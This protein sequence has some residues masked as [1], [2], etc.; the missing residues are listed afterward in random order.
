MKKKFRIFRKVARSFDEELPILSSR[1]AYVAQTINFYQSQRRA[2]VL[3]SAT[4]RH[5]YRYSSGSISQLLLARHAVVPFI[6]R[7]D[8]LS[9]LSR[10]RDSD[11][12]ASVQVILGAGG[13]G[14]TRLASE[15]GR[16]SVDLGWIISNAKIGFGSA[17]PLKSKERSTGEKGAIGRLILIDYSDRLD[18]DS[19]VEL[20]AELTVEM[21]GLPLRLLLTARSGDWWSS[22]QYSLSDYGIPV[23]V[24]QLVEVASSRGARIELF[25][26]A[27][28]S[29][30]DHLGIDPRIAPGDP[31]VIECG[32]SSV[33]AVE[34]QALVQVQAQIE[35]RKA[36]LK[37][38]DVS[39]H[40]LEREIINWRRRHSENKC[41]I[42]VKT[43]ARACFLATLVPCVEYEYTKNLIDSLGVATAG[44]SADQIIFDH[45]SYYPSPAGSTDVVLSPILPNRLGEDFIAWQLEGGDGGVEAVDPWMS[46]AIK[47]IIDASIKA[48]KL[49]E[50]A[51]TITI[52]VETSC[53][54]RSVALFHLAPLLESSPGLALYSGPAVLAKL[55]AMPE[56]G[57]KTIRSL[58]EDVKEKPGVQFSEAAALLA[59]RIALSLEQEAGHAKEFI[60][61]S[62]DA[63]SFFSAAGRDRDAVLML[64]KAMR[65]SKQLSNIDPE[66]SLKSYASILGSL[67]SALSETGR[68]KMALSLTWTSVEL[69]R[70]I[71]QGDENCRNV[72]ATHQINLGNRLTD[73][74]RYNDALAVVTDAV[75]SLSLQATRRPTIHIMEQLAHAQVSL[76]NRLAKLGQIDEARYA[77]ERSVTT[78]GWLVRR[79]PAEYNL[80][81]AISLINFGCRLSETGQ[82]QEALRVTVKAEEILRQIVEQNYWAGIRWHVR[83]LMNLALRNSE[84]G[85]FDKFVTTATEA[86]SI[87]RKLYW[88]EPEAYRSELT[89]LLVVHA[90]A[91]RK[92]GDYVAALE[93]AFEAQKYFDQSSN[94]VAQFEEEFEGGLLALIGGLLLKQSNLASA[95]WYLRRAVESFLGLNMEV[96]ITK[97]AMLAS[98]ASDYS[99]ALS[100]MNDQEGSY[101]FTNLALYLYSALAERDYAYYA[102]DVAVCLGNL[103][104]RC[105]A[106]GRPM[107]AIEASYSA[108]DL[109]ARLMQ[110]DHT[111]HF[112]KFIV[113][114][115]NLEGLIRTV[116]MPRAIWASAMAVDRLR[117]LEGFPGEVEWCE[118]QIRL[119][120]L[121]SA[122]MIDDAEVE[123]RVQAKSVARE[124]LSIYESNIETLSD[125]L[126][127]QDVVQV[128]RTIS[129]EA[130][131]GD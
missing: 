91:L 57:I 101:N 43:M 30:A 31:S 5:E 55:A 70:H 18:L 98:A 1:D 54:Q 85:N 61:L 35:N 7:V 72:L 20:I 17:N 68:H 34:M 26:L 107:G 119:L 28:E 51:M 114:G 99:L 89:R 111:K 121:Y 50:L 56:L 4:P 53:R 39:I 73:A 46:V 77:T 45:R 113:A 83:A 37:S 15:F 74:R 63:A 128:A 14:K 123:A 27:Y 94:D 48:S 112:N 40:L 41:A 131:P 129:E 106:T 52:L 22:L 118:V 104:W 125:N 78:Y 86:V 42:G 21:N 110:D 38:T 36:P 13:Q 87:G 66:V 100:M 6:G 84:A 71:A 115:R 105:M 67:G 102:E 58:Y 117:E 95:V 127:I 10:W 82:R 93:V 59:R 19:I 11:R 122:I 130:T 3:H 88:R 108:F 65:K 8:E 47:K 126:D 81:Y 62:V 2:I 116:C 44:E 23:C 90:G 103:S 124:A 12:K 33:L 80:G 32:A 69:W 109:M 76:G 97:S 75:I 16:R 92:S 60:L 120:V 64:F 25:N 49:E 9:K 29:F 96:T 79:N 24:D